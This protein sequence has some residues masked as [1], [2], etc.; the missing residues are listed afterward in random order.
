[1]LYSLLFF[2]YL[3]Y[4]LPILKKCFF[5]VNGNYFILK[6]TENLREAHV[7]GRIATLARQ[8]HLQ[9][10]KGQVGVIFI[11][12]ASSSYCLVCSIRLLYI[13]AYQV[14]RLYWM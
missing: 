10:D 9:H 8:E 6:T 14:P 1:M 3:R 4:Y 13:L 7:I 5:D 12:R 11:I 2:Y